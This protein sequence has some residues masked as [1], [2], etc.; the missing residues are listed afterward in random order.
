MITWVQLNTQPVYT[1]YTVEKVK[2]I[3]QLSGLAFRRLLSIGSITRPCSLSGG[4]ESAN[5]S[6][7]LNNGDGFLTEFFRIPPHRAK[8]LVSG[9]HDERMF[10]LFRGTL[11]KVT[12]GSEIQLDIE[13]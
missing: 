4:S 1:F 3:V 6:V 7:L 12:M 10:E 11:S 2:D 8:T 5:L 13:F 9:Y